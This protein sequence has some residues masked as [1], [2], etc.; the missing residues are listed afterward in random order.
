MK[1]FKILGARFDLVALCMA[2]T[3][4]RT[5]AHRTFGKYSIGKSSVGE[6][7]MSKSQNEQSG[8]TFIDRKKLN[9]LVYESFRIEE[10]TNC[11]SDIICLLAFKNIKLFIQLA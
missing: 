6:N 11:P 5:F 10:D 7:P 3:G 1:N 2:M 4:W 9:S 8:T